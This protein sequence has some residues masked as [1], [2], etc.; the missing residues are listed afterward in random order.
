[1]PRKPANTAG[2]Q[3]IAGRRRPRAFDTASIASTYR[4]S[5][6]T[7]PPPPPPDDGALTVTFAEAVFRPPGPTHSSSKVVLAVKGSVCWVLEEDEADLLPLH[8]PEAVQE[9]AL[10]ADHCNVVRCP[11]VTDAGEAVNVTTG[12]GT[13]SATLSP[14]VP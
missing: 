5:G 7:C 6:S 11:E 9:V 2:R 12:G 14:N 1:M 13:E 3:P 4:S 10:V 8:P